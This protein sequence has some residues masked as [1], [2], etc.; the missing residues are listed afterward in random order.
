MLT[1]LNLE[2]RMHHADVDADQLT[3]LDEFDATRYR[4]YLVRTYG[5]EASVESALALT[6]GLERVIDL[7]QRAKAGRIAQ[8]LL[9]LGLRPNEL[10][11]VPLCTFID[12]CDDVLDAMGWLYVLERRTLLHSAIL[13]H[14]VARMP[15]IVDHAGSYLR[16]YEGIAGARWRDLGAT[17]DQIATEMTAPRVIAAA[18]QALWCQRDWFHTERSRQQAG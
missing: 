7:R 14:L 3:V 18:H 8:D 5:F 1:Q 15:A 6:P 4:D 16:S 17:Y 10:S 9:A 13:R 11:E 2:T 12:D